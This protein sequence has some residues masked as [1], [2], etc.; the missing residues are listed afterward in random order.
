MPETTNSFKKY[1][2]ILKFIDDF[3][4]ER[5]E[6]TGIKENQAVS[7]YDI[8]ESIGLSVRQTSRCVNEIVSVDGRYK[9]TKIGRATA[10][11]KGD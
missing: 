11:I 2:D 6:L 3:I 9:L 8:A 7:I 10:I 5:I 4:K 1:F